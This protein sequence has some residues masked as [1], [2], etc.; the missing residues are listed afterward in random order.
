MGWLGTEQ[1][2]TAY[3]AQSWGSLFLETE[4]SYFKRNVRE[5]GKY[6]EVK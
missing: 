3:K 4:S 1:Q 5:K 6:E 2:V